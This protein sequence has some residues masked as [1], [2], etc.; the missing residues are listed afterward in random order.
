MLA[1]WAELSLGYKERLLLLLTSPSLLCDLWLWIRNRQLG[2]F[3]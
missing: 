1:S 3:Q 2:T